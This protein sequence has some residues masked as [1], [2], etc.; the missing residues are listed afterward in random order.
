MND[1][2]SVPTRL[3][4]LEAMLLADPQDQT[5]RYML[6]ME[7]KKT[8]D[9]ARCIDCF[10]QLM[11]EATPYVPAFLMCGQLQ[12]ELGQID[13]ARQTFR[14]GIQEAQKQNNDHAAGEMSQFL[15]SLP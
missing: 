2:A 7:L 11:A 13:A 4:K 10:R 12:G 14:D 9:H 1:S 15:Q 5:L 6:A 8:G 3:E